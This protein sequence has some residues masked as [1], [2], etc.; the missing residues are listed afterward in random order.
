MIER[1]PLPDMRSA[2]TRKFQLAY[3][4]DDG[5]S[6]IMKFYFTVGLY[7]D[8]RPGEVFIKADRSGTLASGALEGIAIMMSLGLQY[9]IPME[10]LVDKLRGTRFDPSGFT[11]VGDIPSCTSPLDLLA[12]WLLQRFPSAPGS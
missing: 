7:E 10:A 1:K 11:K 6:D 3:T 4:R 2:I 8:G 9:G 12:K 5:T